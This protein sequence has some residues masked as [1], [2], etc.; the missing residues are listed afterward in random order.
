MREEVILYRMRDGELFIHWPYPHE[1]A[2]DAA[3]LWAATCAG[4]TEVYIVNVR[5]RTVVRTFPEDG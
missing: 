2:A 5:T 4:C 3:R 1:T